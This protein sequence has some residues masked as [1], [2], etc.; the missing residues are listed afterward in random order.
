MAAPTPVRALVHSSTLVTAGVYVLIRYSDTSVEL[1]LFVGTCTILIA[2]LRACFER[3]LKKVVALS[4]LSQL[5]VMIVSLG[6][7]EKSYCFFHLISHA[8]FKALLFLCIGSSIHA[9]YGTQEYR[10]FN[11]APTLLLSRCRAVSVLSLIGFVYLSGFYRKDM[12]LE[13]LYGSEGGAFALCMFLLGVG[14]TSCYRLKIIAATIIMGSYTGIGA[15]ALGGVGWRVKGPLSVL[16]ILR[17]VLGTTSTCYRSPL[18]LSTSLFDKIL[19]VFFIT[20]GVVT[21]YGLTR[22]KNHLMRSLFSLT[23]L[24]QIRAYFPLHFDQQKSVDKGWIHL[25]ATSLTS[26]ANSIITL[27]RPVISLGLRT[28][29]FFFLL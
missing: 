21:G 1:M 22:Y 24:C 6:A 20:F 25:C 27:H 11:I 14:L 19:P 7:Y 18:M 9:I 26:V 17:I 16:V 15:S 23:P 29:C 4:T 10:R 8:C 3:D 5:G 2:G 28:I 12:I 13:A